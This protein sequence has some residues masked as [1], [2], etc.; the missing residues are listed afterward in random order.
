MLM[1][2]YSTDV[3]LK[4][5]GMAMSILI[6]PQIRFISLFRSIPVM[7]HPRKESTQ[8]DLVASSTLGVVA[9]MMKLNNPLSVV[10]PLYF[11]LY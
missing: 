1:L 4:I 11:F 3:N 8:L 10:N 9:N 2:R 7:F 6:T 5:A